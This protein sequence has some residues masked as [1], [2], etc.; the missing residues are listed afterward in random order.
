MPAIE[1]VSDLLAIAAFGAR[2][3]LDAPPDGEDQDCYSERQNG[4]GPPT[5]C[6]HRYSPSREMKS[7][8]SRLENRPRAAN[9]CPRCKTRERANRGRPKRETILNDGELADKKKLPEKWG[10]RC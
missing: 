3:A 10:C 7:F 4:N 9:A 2:V 5:V 6:F 8:A 1:R